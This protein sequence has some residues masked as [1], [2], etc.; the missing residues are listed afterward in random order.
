MLLHIIFVLSGLF[1]IQ[2]RIQNLFRKSLE[3]VL[4][5][6]MKKDKALSPSLWLSAQPAFPP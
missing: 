5:I 4:K 3:K 1:Q 2:K 6:K